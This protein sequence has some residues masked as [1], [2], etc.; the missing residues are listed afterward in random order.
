MDHW[1]LCKDIHH[2]GA[3]RPRR[4]GGEHQPRDGRGEDQGNEELPHDLRKTYQALVCNGAIV[5]R[6]EVELPVIQM[7]YKRV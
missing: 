2:R 6:K 7:N 1:Y 4:F 5:P 3:V